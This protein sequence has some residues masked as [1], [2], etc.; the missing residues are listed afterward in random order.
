[1]FFVSTDSEL[2]QKLKQVLQFKQNETSFSHI[3]STHGITPQHQPKAE[4][5]FKTSSNTNI[6]KI[7][8]LSTNNSNHTNRTSAQRPQSSTTSRTEQFNP[9][10]TLTL[11]ELQSVSRNNIKTQSPT[12]PSETLILKN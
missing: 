11:L 1:M 4:P 6:S 8:S 5:P 12:K 7:C 10:K 9:Q 2:A 3:T